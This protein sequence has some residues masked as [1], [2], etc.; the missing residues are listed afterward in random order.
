[1]TELNLPPIARA[2]V[3]AP[4]AKET[5]TCVNLEFVRT[6]TSCVSVGES[7]DVKRFNGTTGV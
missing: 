3:L 1:M 6:A 5:L 7:G 4:F 2:E